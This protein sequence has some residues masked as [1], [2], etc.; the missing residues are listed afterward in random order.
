M[1]LMSEVSMHSFAG[2]GSCNLEGKGVHA[3][4]A[5]GG[6]QEYLAHKKPNSPLGPP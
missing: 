4:L 2:R 1:S 6:V 3:A 5:Y